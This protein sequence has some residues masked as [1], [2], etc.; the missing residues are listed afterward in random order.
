MAMRR[1]YAAWIQRANFCVSRDT[2]R[3]VQYVEIAFTAPAG[4]AD[5]WAA[6]LFEWGVEIRDAETLEKPPAGKVIL[7][8]WVPP[9]AAEDVMARVHLPAQTRARDES[10]WRELWK[11]YFKPRRVGRFVIVPSWE[12]Y[13]GPE[14]RLELDPGRAFGTG[15]HPSTRLCLE[16]L[17]GDVESFLDVGC[18]SG[19]LAIACKKLWPAARGMGMDIDPEAVEV[20]RENAARN[21]VDVPFSTEIP[22]G[23]FDLVLANIQPEVLIPMAPALMATGKKLILSG[24]LV[25]AADEVVKAYSGMRLTKT[26]DDEGWRV[27]VLEK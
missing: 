17:E 5:E 7:V 10:E 12:T 18:G 2:V 22:E 26:R 6:E 25:E 9:D 24:I 23:R 14:V 4:E 3:A 16:M 8:V 13:D 21:R 19:V 20:S 11:K 15:Q 27:L 1:R